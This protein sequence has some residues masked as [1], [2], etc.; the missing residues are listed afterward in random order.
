VQPYDFSKLAS[1]K[2]A[3]F[4]ENMVTNPLFTFANIYRQQKFLSAP[5]NQN[6]PSGCG[7]GI[8]AWLTSIMFAVVG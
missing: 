6:M 8:W 7:L 4:L 2:A 3:N 1:H 5:V